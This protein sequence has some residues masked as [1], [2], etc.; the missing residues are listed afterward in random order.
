MSKSRAEAELALQLRAVSIGMVRE[1]GFHPTRR[2]RFDFA[3]PEHYLAVEIEGVKY[4]KPG[5][6]QRVDGMNADCEK[7]AEALLLGWSVLRV[8]PQQVRSGLAIRW[9]E[10]WY[11]G[12]SK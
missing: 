4:G 7:Y 2:W 6:H 10:R 1:Y 12:K 5:R 9:I 3:D 8:T 11:Q